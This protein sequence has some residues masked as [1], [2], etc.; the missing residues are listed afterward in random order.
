MKK[1]LDKPENVVKYDVKVFDVLDREKGK[2]F[3]RLLGYG[4]ADHE[5]VSFIDKWLAGKTEGDIYKIEIR[6]RS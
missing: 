3:G 4:A 6:R 5:V 2:L 1:S